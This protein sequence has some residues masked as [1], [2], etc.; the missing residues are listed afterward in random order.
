MKKNSKTKRE[1]SFKILQ[2]AQRFDKTAQVLFSNL[3]QM[4]ELTIPAYCNAG[5][6]MELYLKFI[7]NLEKGTFGETHKLDELYQDLS[8]QSQHDIMI[9]FNAGLSDVNWEVIKEIEKGSGVTHSK[10][11]RVN[12]SYLA[13]A[14]VDVRY[15]FDMEYTRGVNWLFIDQ[16]RS[17]I[18]SVAFRLFEN[19]K[20]QP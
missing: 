19:Y 8:S 7:S 13:R 15:F 6:A 11:L 20:K 16:I 3:Q 9:L 12:L 18:T 2:Q 5:I 1:D 4:P 17:A 10:D 14:I